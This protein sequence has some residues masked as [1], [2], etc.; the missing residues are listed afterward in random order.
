MVWMSGQHYQERE[1]SPI[2]KRKKI[3]VLKANNVTTEELPHAINFTCYKGEIV[4]IAG[5]AG[6]GRSELLNA[7]FGL[8]SL[9]GGCVSRFTENGTISIDKTSRAVR[10]G[11]GYLGE[12]RRSMGLFLGQSIIVNVMLPGNPR[13][14]RSFGLLDRAQERV[15]GTELLNRLAIKC[16]GLDQDIDQLSGGNQ[17]KVLIARWLH[18][19]SEIFLLDEPTR[20]VD[21]GTKNAIYRL[22]FELQSRHKTVVIVSSEIDELMTVCGRILVLSARKLVG[23]F[24]RD[25]WSKTSILAAAFQEFAGES[26]ATNHDSIAPAEPANRVRT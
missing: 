25:E 14:G 22:L 17:Q 16:D 2:A 11:V 1:I 24:K 20:G 4:G 7:L 5:L 13:V 12:D 3:P 26:P 6:A 18:H 9:T 23:E 19:D 10:S 15:A 21:V 8:T